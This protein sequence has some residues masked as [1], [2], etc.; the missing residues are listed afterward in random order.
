MQLTS[1]VDNWKHVSILGNN[2]SDDISDLGKGLMISLFGALRH[3]T[4]SKKVATAKAFVTPKRLPH[5]SPATSFHSQRVYFQIMVWIGMAN[6]MNLIE[7]GWE[8]ESD[9]LIPI[10]TNKN[11]ASDELLKVIHCNCR[12]MQI[13]SMQLQTLWTLSCTAACGP[14]QVENC[15]NPNTTQE[16][17]TEE[18]LNVHGTYSMEKGIAW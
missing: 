13:R 3:V 10:M 2:S 11:V 16:V 1:S 17:D 14:C 4:F 7:W 8:K 15:D 18:E 9:E 5:T 6:E 12:G